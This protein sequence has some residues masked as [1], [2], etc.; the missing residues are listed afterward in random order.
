M[1]K[2]QIGLL[3][4]V[5]VFSATS[6]APAEFSTEVLN[7][8]MDGLEELP[9]RYDDLNKQLTDPTSGILNRQNPTLNGEIGQQGNSDKE[10]VEIDP[11]IQ[12]GNNRQPAFIIKNQPAEPTPV[13]TDSPSVVRSGNDSGLQESID[14]VLTE[15]EQM[16]GKNKFTQWF[17]KQWRV[18]TG[19]KSATVQKLINLCKQKADALQQSIIQDYRRLGAVDLLNNGELLKIRTDDLKT[20]IKQ[21][22]DESRFVAGWSKNVRKTAVDVAHNYKI[23]SEEISN[24]LD[25]VFDTVLSDLAQEDKSMRSGN[26]GFDI[27]IET[28]PVFVAEKIVAFESLKSNAQGMQKFFEYC[29]GTGKNLLVLHLQKVRKDYEVYQLLKDARTSD[30]SFKAIS[31]IVKELNAK[32]TKD[33]Q[34]LIAQAIATRSK[35]G[36][37]GKQAPIILTQDVTSPSEADL[38]AMIRSIPKKDRSSSLRRWLGLL[39]ADRNEFAY[40][41][42]KSIFKFNTRGITSEQKATIDDNAQQYTQISTL[43]DKINNL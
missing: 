15:L 40:G 11:G 23:A 36:I 42:M 14:A 6:W 25:T 1:K 10:P 38:I 7:G 27:V 34:E 33:N 16:G 9:D 31:E 43:I 17:Y 4:I 32:I 28:D 30:I 21:L 5:A 37:V 24:Y 26:R 18:L 39:E 3:V 12:G 29:K 20:T 19:K 35:N 13:P 2:I 22:I 41:L 8:G